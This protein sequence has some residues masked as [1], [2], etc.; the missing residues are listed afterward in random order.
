[1]TQ[2][3]TIARDYVKRK[4]ERKEK[5]Y[6]PD[7]IHQILAGSAGIY[8]IAFFG[9]KGTPKQRR[10]NRYLWKTSIIVFKEYQDHNE[11]H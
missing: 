11:K 9:A 4:R 3:K 10:L 1:M 2:W 5:I 6:T 8:G 7:Q